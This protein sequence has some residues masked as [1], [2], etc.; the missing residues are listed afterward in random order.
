MFTHR[1]NKCCRRYQTDWKMDFR[2]DLRQSNKL[3]TNCALI[4]TSNGVRRSS[5]PYVT[6]VCQ[7]V[8][9]LRATVNR[10]EC[11]DCTCQQSRCRWSDPFWIYTQRETGNEWRAKKRCLYSKMINRISSSPWVWGIRNTFSYNSVRML[12]TWATLLVRHEVKVKLPL[13]ESA[14]SLWG[15]RLAYAHSQ[16]RDSSK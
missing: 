12:T 15:M 3:L 6:Q 11:F 9:S 4:H 1:C 7:F 5:S 13:R 16:N 2:T 8:I 10:D 14:I